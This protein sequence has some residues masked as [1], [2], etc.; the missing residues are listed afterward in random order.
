MDEKQLEAL[1]CATNVNNK[2]VSA[3]ITLSLISVCARSD[4]ADIDGLKYI[5]ENPTSINWR[6]EG[7]T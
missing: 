7:I 4:V 2:A 1:K 5:R 3:G 6:G